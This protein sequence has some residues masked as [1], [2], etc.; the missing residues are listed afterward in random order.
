MKRLPHQTAATKF[1]DHER[2]EAASVVLVQREMDFC[3]IGANRK[4]GNVH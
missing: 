3:L 4:T 1:R 2:I